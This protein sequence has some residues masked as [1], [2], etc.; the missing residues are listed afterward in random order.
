MF[1]YYIVLGYIATI[2]LSNLAVLFFGLVNI[3]GL[4]FPAGALFIGLNFSMRDF[5]QKYWNHKVWFFMLISTLLTALLGFVLPSNL[6][7]SPEM[8]AFASASSFIVSESIDWLVYTISKKGIIW[9]ICISN[10]ISIPIDSMLFVGIVFGNYSIFNPPVYGQTIV[11]YL[12]GILIIP[13]IMLIKKR[14]DLKMI[15]IAKLVTGEFVIGQ[16]ESDSLV[17]VMIIRFNINQTT[18]E[19][20]R[21]LIPYMYPISPTLGKIIS[22]DKVVSSIP[23]DEMLSNE[24]INSI[25]ILIENL[26]KSEEAQKQQNEKIGS[27]QGPI[28]ENISETEEQDKNIE[29]SK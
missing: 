15:K 3:F 21:S 11:K 25:K 27:K 13:I 26:K 18:G 17:N 6:S 14:S 19:I 12:S 9:R 28:I 5:T 23:A 2:V 24:Y 29:C 7:V 4:I 20:S 1:K 22:Y 16:D 8:V 10:I